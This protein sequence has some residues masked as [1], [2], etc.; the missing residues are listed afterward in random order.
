G[1]P[2]EARVLPEIVAEPGDEFRAGPLRIEVLSAAAG[3]QGVRYR[4]SGTLF[5]APARTAKAATRRVTE[6][7]RGDSDPAAAA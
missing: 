2:P 6:P 3:G 5:P 7:R 1:G 4:V